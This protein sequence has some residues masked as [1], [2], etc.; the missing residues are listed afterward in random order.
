MKTMK[1]RN[2]GMADCGQRNGS[3][4]SVKSLHFLRLALLLV[5]VIGGKG[6]AFL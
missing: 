5:L 4:W 1:I 6:M 3:L 2:N